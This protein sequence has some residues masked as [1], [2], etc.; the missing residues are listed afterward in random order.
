MQ[1]LYPFKG[2]RG[3]AH[4]F[5][6]AYTLWAAAQGTS[7]NIVDQERNTVDQKEEEWIC[8]VLSYLHDDA[9]V[10]AAPAMKEFSDRQVPF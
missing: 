4:R 1:K 6:A 7:L 3:K 2:D 5:L 8:S 10:W 9:V